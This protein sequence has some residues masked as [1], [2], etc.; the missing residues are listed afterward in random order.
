VHSGT[1]SVSPVPDGCDFDGT[2]DIVNQIEDPVVAAT[3]GVSRGQ[4]WVEGFADTMGVVKQWP[5]D[6]FECGVGDLLG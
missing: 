3:C 2:S 1:I 4:R 5:I 6:E